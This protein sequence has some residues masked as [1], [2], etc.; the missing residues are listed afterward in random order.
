[1]TPLASSKSRLFMV[2]HTAVD[3]NYAGICYGARDVELSAEGRAQI[4]SVAEQ[5]AEYQPSRI[6]HSGLQ[7]TTHLARAVADKVSYPV[8]LI[9]DPRL[10]EINFGAWEGETWDAIYAS[11][12]DIARLIHEPQ[13]FSPPGGETTF[14]LRDRVLDWVQCL[15]REYVTIAVAHGG[16][17]AALRGL[18]AGRPINEWPSLVPGLGEIVE[19]DRDSFLNG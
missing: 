5:L 11:G 18:L 12:Q 15:P 13:T 10:A 7:R 3:T 17:I 16:P 4:S 19:L 6:Y 14:T 9:A 8:K 2:R 1:M